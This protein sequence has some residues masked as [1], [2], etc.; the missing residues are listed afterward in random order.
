VPTGNAVAS[1]RDLDEIAFGLRFRSRLPIGRAD[2]GIERSVRRAETFRIETL[3]LRANWSFNLGSDVLGSVQGAAAR[4][5]GTDGP[6]RTLS[7]NASIVWWAHRSLSLRATLG[8]W[9]RKIRDSDASFFGGG[10]AAEWRRG[11]S[12]AVLRY[13]RAQWDEISPRLDD[14][15]SVILVREF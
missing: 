15:V 8:S 9:R 14:R 1:L 12:L 5:E 7:G 11:K 10:L 4:T 6:S 3:E 13:D 2:A